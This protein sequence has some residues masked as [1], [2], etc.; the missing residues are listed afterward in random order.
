MLTIDDTQIPL[1]SH[2]S[3]DVYH[4]AVRYNTVHYNNTKEYKIM[5]KE[6][7][8]IEN[9]KVLDNFNKALDDLLDYTRTHDV[10][11]KRLRSSS[12]YVI[13]TDNYY[14]LRSYN[15]IVAVIDKHNNICYDALRHVY[16]YT[17]TSAHHIS[18]FCAD[19][20][21]SIYHPGTRYVFRNI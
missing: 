10:P 20:G 3:R 16:G 13:E 2:M 15:T 19:Y 9:V 18:K 12:A 4:P 6:N 8:V 5:R 17:A 21:I 14:L 11:V 7:Q 1:Q